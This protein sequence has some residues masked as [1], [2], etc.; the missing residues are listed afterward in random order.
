[1]FTVHSEFNSTVEIA[2]AN[3]YPNIRV[4]TVG[5]GGTTSATLLTQLGSIKQPWSVASAA[6]I[7]VADWTAFSAVC[8]HFGRNLFDALGKTVPIG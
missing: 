8:W 6:T 7:G 3:N 1:M 4:F 2:R 5:E